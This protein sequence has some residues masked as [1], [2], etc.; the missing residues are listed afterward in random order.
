[1][2]GSLSKNLIVTSALAFTIYLGFGLILPLFPSYVVLLGGGGTEVGILLASFMLTRAFL[3][4]PFGK[5]SDRIGRKKV[6]IAGMFT[7]AVLAYLFTIPDNWFGLIFVRLLQGS[8]SAMVWPVGEALVID[9]AP[10]E[11]R[12]KAISIY[13]IISNIGFIAGPFIGSGI[14]YFA[15]YSLHTSELASVRMPF[16]FTCAISLIGAVVGSIMLMDALPPLKDQLKRKLEVK[17]ALAK[18]KPHIK[19]SLYFL[20]SNSFF[21]GFSWSLGSVVM[22]L[23]MDQAFDMPNEVFSILFGLSQAIGLI[24]VFPSGVLSDRSRK[25]PFV[26]YGSLVSK[27][28][29]IIMALT[30][31]I[32]MGYWL[33]WVFFAGKD[34]GRQ[35]A[36]P[37]TRSLQADLSPVRIRGRLIATIQ[38]Y[39][40]AGSL[41]GSLAG[42]LIWDHTHDRYYSIILMDLPGYTVPFFFSAI[43]GTIAALLVLRYVHEPPKGRTIG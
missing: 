29:T 4:R 38:S 42:G 21:E 32:P 26:V 36:S 20:Y 25:K 27:L 22:Y 35:I 28:S 1:M 31:I 16:Y 41:I 9:S 3:A 39:S 23:F 6:I 43:M 40:N 34:A 2:S 10:P 11:K 24:F 17:K 5:L 37:A 12:S 33:S 19:R 7:Y 13:M 15:I 8:A 30:P 14:Q 18:L